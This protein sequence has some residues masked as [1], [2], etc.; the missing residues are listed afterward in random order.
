MLTHEQLTGKQKEAYEAQIKHAKKIFPVGVHDISNEDYHGSAGIS[1]SGICQFKKTPHH[2]WYYYLNENKEASE[3]SYSM[4]L[5]TALHVY[6]TETNCFWDRYVIKPEI[7]KQSKAGK[8]ES[9][10]WESEHRHLIKLTNNDWDKIRY[11]T[12]SVIKNEDAYSLIVDALY[13]KSLYW[14]DEKTGLLCKARP[15]VWYPDLIV[16]IKTTGSGAKKDFENSIHKYG[17]YIQAGMIL[18]S[19]KYAALEEHQNYAFV[20]VE[21]K[22]PYASGVYQL[23]EGD[24]YS[25]REDY[26]TALLGIAEC[27]ET[28]KWP[29]YK[30][31]TVSRPRWATIDY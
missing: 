10:K 7:N 9:E 1:R 31:T 26:K 4:F 21:N 15:D 24:I 13:E 22:E 8:E 16:D 11:M 12:D 2:Y 29:Q 17:Y 6:L 25:G 19:L 3:E 18:D 5:G 27:Y 23:H 30:Q 20:I 28:N 14:I